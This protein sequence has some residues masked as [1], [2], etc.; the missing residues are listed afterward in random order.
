VSQDILAI[1]GA[2]CCPMPSDPEAQ[3]EIYLTSDSQ[4]LTPKLKEALKSVEAS[5][6]QMNEA[7]RRAM[8]AGVIIELR[9]RHRVHSGNGC[10]ADQMAPL[11]QARQHT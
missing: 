8:E 7:V 1:P 10:W 6:A 2:G 4:K 3:R 5:V 11:V 9:R